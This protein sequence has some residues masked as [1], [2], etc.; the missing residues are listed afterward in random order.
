MCVASSYDAHNEH[1][2]TF[3]TTKIQIKLRA[4]AMHVIHVAL[5]DSSKTSTMSNV[6]VK[7]FALLASRNS[8]NRGPQHATSSEAAEALVS[9]RAHG[10]SADG[11]LSRPA[12]VARFCARHA[13]EPT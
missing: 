7:S 6:N 5:K 12:R 3:I 1:S 2:P 4:L 10:D 8:R 13:R 9:T 11:V